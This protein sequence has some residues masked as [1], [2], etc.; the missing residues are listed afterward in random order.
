MKDYIEF[1]FYSI[2]KIEAILSIETYTDSQK[3]KL[4]AGIVSEVNEKL[5]NSTK[6]DNL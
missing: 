4:I 3:I 1:A 2:G 5:Q 6:E